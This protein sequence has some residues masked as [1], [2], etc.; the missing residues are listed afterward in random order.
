MKKE[1]VHPD[2]KS[3]YSMLDEKNQLRV[4]EAEI[5]KEYE[6]II[7][8]QDEEGDMLQWQKE[9]KKQLGKMLQDCQ[10][11]IRHVKNKLKERN[12]LSGDMPSY[13]A[14]QAFIEIV[15]QNVDRETWI[16]IFE[17]YKFRKRDYYGE[18][19]KL[20]DALFDHK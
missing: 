14:I 10:N 17:E 9:K 8:Q 3:F 5:R 16:K 11:N 6:A 12:E 18:I 20:R 13:P 7:A 1:E 2:S 4:L 19:D 15:K